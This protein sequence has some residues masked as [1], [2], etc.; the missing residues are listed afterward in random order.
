[1]L[2]LFLFAGAVWIKACT[3]MCNFLF[4]IMRALSYDRLF[5]RLSHSYSITC[6]FSQEV[7]VLITE[8]GA[9][10]HKYC[11][12]EVKLLSLEIDREQKKCFYI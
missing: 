2:Y 12:S 1:L 10:F 4:G 9:A 8:L 7:I 5:R 3:S 11:A 6:S